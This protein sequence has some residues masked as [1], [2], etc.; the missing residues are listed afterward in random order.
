[1]SVACV[2]DSNPFPNSPHWHGTEHS[3]ISSSIIRRT[4]IPRRRTHYHTT[5]TTTILGVSFLK[6][7]FILYDHAKNGS[8]M[9]FSRYCESAASSHGLFPTKAVGCQSSSSNVFVSF[10]TTTTTTSV[11]LF[12]VT[13]HLRSFPSA[14]PS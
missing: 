14:A 9:A 8:K 6:I 5:V 12:A 11:S 1:M 4:H 10:V 3:S 2:T 13:N 7:F